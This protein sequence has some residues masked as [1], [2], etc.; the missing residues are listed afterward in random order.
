MKPINTEFYHEL[1]VVNPALVKEE[2]PNKPFGES[3]E[4]SSDESLIKFES[5]RVATMRDAKDKT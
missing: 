5:R 4:V 1:G 3:D 2:L